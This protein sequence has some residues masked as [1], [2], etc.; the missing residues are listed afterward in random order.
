MWPNEI[1]DVDTFMIVDCFFA[2][3]ALFNNKHLSGDEAG[4][5]TLTRARRTWQISATLNMR[6]L[7]SVFC[8]SRTQGRSTSF[9]EYM[10]SPT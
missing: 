10:F 7:S 2:S 9:A 5:P 4:G 1:V 6:L 8:A 3:N